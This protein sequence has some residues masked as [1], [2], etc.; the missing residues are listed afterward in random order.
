M[1]S[2]KLEKLDTFDP[3]SWGKIIDKAV[4]R[5]RTLLWKNDDR[6]TLVSS[7]QVGPESLDFDSS[8]WPQSLDTGHGIEPGP[9]PAGAETKANGEKGTQCWCCGSLRVA[10]NWWFVLCAHVPI[11]DVNM[12]GVH[13]VGCAWNMRVPSCTSC[14]IE[15]DACLNSTHDLTI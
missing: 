13:F 14:F 12:F 1:F 2:L 9:K 7:F 11:P 10:P 15:V 5:R 3:T 4:Y 6:K 8:C